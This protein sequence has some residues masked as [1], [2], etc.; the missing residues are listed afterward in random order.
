VARTLKTGSPAAITRFNCMNPNQDG[1]LPAILPGQACLRLFW[2][3]PDVRFSDD[4]AANHRLSHSGFFQD[5]L[6]LFV[7]AGKR[8]GNFLESAARE[9][10]R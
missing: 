4:C 3:V 10:L 5:P 9:G 1:R 8:N 7:I 2:G 6:V